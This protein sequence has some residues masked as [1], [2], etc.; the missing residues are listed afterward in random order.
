[1]LT[2]VLFVFFLKCIYCGVVQSIDFWLI[3]VDTIMGR[4]KLDTESISQHGKPKSRHSAENAFDS[5][6]FQGTKQRN[7]IHHGY[8]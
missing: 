5:L 3:S 7:E 2:Y 8:Q 6:K 4:V 1:M